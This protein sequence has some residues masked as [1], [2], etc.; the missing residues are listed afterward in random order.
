MYG[1]EIRDPGSGK[2]LSG[3]RIQGDPGSA[4]LAGLPYYLIQLGNSLV[5]VGSGG[6]GGVASKPPPPLKHKLS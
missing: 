4:T 2:N 3:I 6:R 5:R 1:V